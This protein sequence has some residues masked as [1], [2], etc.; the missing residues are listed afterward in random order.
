MKRRA[1]VDREA[2]A[3]EIVSLP[4]LGIDDLR[5]RW[6]AMFGKA[7]SQEIGRSFLIRAIAYHLQER[8]YGG[9]KPSTRRLLAR[10]IL[11]ARGDHYGG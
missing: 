8:A 2:L 6:K 9:L 5:E 10:V 4:K 1:A 3:S 7:P 11:R